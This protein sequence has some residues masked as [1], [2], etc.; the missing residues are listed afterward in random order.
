MNQN[1]YTWNK[2]LKFSWGHI[3]AF[4]AIIAISYLAYMGEF[5]KNGGDFVF[6]AI[7]VGIIDVCLMATFLGAQIYK[8]KNERFDTA[9]TVERILIA[10]CPVAFVFAMIPCNHFWNVHSKKE[11]IETH[12]HRVISESEEMFQKYDTYTTERIQALDNNLRTSYPEDPLSQDNYVRT[13]TLQ[14]QSDNIQHLKTSALKWIHK[15]D[16]GVSVWNAFLVGNI[17]QI[18]AAI[19]D[20][21]G[22]LATASQ[23]IL[24]MESQ[25]TRP[26]DVNALTFQSLSELQTLYTE[27]Q[28]L[29]LRSILTGI[30]LFLMLIFP[31]LLQ[32]R[33]IRAQGYYAL[34]PTAAKRTKSK[35]VEHR[36]N[37]GDEGDNETSYNN[38]DDTDI[39][40]GT[41]SF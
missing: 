22:S 33:C 2:V 11:K 15:T 37:T 30:L 28:G 29:S 23:P 8:G 17:K 40:S 1:I 6:A 5:Y 14:L 10:L 32:E 9:I 12:F 18:S 7:K 19:A 21:K 16:Q 3:I 27:S 13:L 25:D 38:T 35:P 31:Y 34:F 26:F 24:S 36:V 20:W 41:I 4:I 39:Y